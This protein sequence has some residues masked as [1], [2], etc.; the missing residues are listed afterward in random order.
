MKLMLI[1]VLLV[2]FFV[3]A[4]GQQ[5]LCFSKNC[6]QTPVAIFKLDRSDTQLANIFRPLPA[7]PAYQPVAPLAFSP[8]TR[9]FFRYSV[10]AHVDNG[11]S[12]PKLSKPAPGETG[13]GSWMGTN[14]PSGLSGASPTGPAFSARTFSTGQ[15]GIGFTP[16]SR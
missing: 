15:G 5:Q 16:A 14:Y 12:L 2:G 11:L 3:P 6:S 13:H 10:P 7:L 8:S 9:Q 4:Y 1:V